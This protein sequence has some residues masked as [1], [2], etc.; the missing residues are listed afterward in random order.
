MSTEPNAVSY[1]KR[2][3]LGPEGNQIVRCTYPDTNANN[4]LSY[5]IR[6]V[7][8]IRSHTLQTQII[9]SVF[10]RIL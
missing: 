10:R 9:L 4:N 5:N 1:D 7:G 3:G 8:S 2:F 6:R